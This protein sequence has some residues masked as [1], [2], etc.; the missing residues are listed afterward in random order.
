MSAPRNRKPAHDRDDEWTNYPH[1]V[2]PDPLMEMSNRG[3]AEESCRRLGHIRTA[4]LAM[5]VAVAVQMLIGMAG[6]AVMM[7]HLK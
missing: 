6:C 1:K 4:V 3:L 5:A 7:S 2:V